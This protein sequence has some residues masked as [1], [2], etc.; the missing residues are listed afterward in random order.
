LL[1]AIRD[2]EQHELQHLLLRRQRTVGTAFRWE[3]L[4]SGRRI[5]NVEVAEQ[6]AAAL[7]GGRRSNRRVERVVLDRAWI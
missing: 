4:A 5:C 3:R 6:H 7:I 1:D 2:I